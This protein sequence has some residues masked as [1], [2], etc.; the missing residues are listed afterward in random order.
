MLCEKCK[1]NE[2]TVYYRETVNGKTKSWS[3][4]QDC[5]NELQQAN[6]GKQELANF[7]NEPF[8][9][10]FGNDFLHSLLSPMGGNQ[11]WSEE[12]RCSLCGASFDDIV[13]EGKVGCPK[14]Y[15]T[16]EKELEESVRRIHGTSS[17]TGRVPGKL[18]AKFDQK[19]KI[20]ELERQQKEA[21]KNENYEEAA[22]IRDELKALKSSE[23]SKG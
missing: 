14:C 2:A 15:E 16:F 11:F 7:W 6:H 8:E 5:F 18:K 13:A 20:A 19:K 3:L 10:F 1:K 23:E 17:H 21:V 22:R 12:K 9:D 4:C